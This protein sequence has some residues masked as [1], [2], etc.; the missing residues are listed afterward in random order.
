MRDLW[1]GEPAE[2]L[3]RERH[4]GMHRQRRMTTGEDQPQPV[5]PHR[6]LLEWFVVGVQQRRLRVPVG[7]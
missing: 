5:V 6:T 1:R 3:E 4:L 7:T 2:Q